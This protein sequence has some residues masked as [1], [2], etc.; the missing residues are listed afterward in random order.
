M[1]DRLDELPGRRCSIAGALDV[2]GDRWALLVV[3]EVSLG[4]H[5]FSEI[6]RGTGAPREQLTARLGA[7]VDAGVLERRPYSDSP[8]RSDYHLTRA[9]RDLLPVLQA[10]MQWGDRYVADEPPVEFHHAGHRISASWVCDV[11]GEPVGRGLERHV[12][13]RHDPAPR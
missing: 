5:R 12:R 6:R 4:A 2:V 3:R 8:P 13:E 10:L 9:G 1:A 11:C 7:L